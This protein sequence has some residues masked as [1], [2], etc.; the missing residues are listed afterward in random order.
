MYYRRKKLAEIYWDGYLVWAFQ[1]LLLLWRAMLLG[2]CGA[3]VWG[4]LFGLSCRAGSLKVELVPPP[5]LASNQSIAANE[6]DEPEAKKVSKEVVE[7]VIDD[8]FLNEMLHAG[9]AQEAIGSTGGEKVRTEIGAYIKRFL[10]VAKVEQQKYGIPVSITLGQGLLESRRGKS[11]LAED[12]NNHFGIKC[13][14]AHKHKKAGCHYAKDEA[15]MG[16]QPFK[17]Y[18][19][20]WACY[21]DH[22]ILIATSKRYKHLPKKFSDTDYKGWAKGI[23]DA[24]YASDR[25]YAQKLIA[26]IK[27]LGLYRY[28]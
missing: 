13:F 24:G 27:A 19:S 8:D 5:L 10:A 11:K 17:A 21:R 26:L 3:L 15:W 23:A 1:P 4:M 14:A 28:D 6:D 25:R 9:I 22:S 20:A 18:Q 7:Q 16:R 12:A 2:V